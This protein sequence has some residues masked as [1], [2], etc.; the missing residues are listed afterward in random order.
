MIEWS[1]PV[2]CFGNID[3]SQVAT[4]G[5][6]PSNR[7]FVDLSG[8]ELQN[9]HRRF[10]TLDSLGLLKWDDYKI[11]HLNKISESCI[12]YFNRNPY[13][14]WF[15][16]LDYLISGSDASYYFPISNACHLD[17]IPYATSKKWSHLSIE[18]KILLLELC[19]DT[20]GHLIKNSPIKYLILNGQTVVDNLQKIALVKLQK[21][22]VQEWDLKRKGVYSVKGYSYTG[23]ITKIGQVELNKE[24]FVLGYNHNIQSSFGVS[25][26]VMTSIRNW[27]TDN[28]KT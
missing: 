11:E 21:E 25:L 23:I 9:E 15:K 4:L 13:D 8:F 19:D 22:N 18:Q 17:L 26:E 20:L 5:I 2:I 28:I 12:E 7:E 14:N 24:V 1:S 16:K 10:H 6:N 27:L 3:N